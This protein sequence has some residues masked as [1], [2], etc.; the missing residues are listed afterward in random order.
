VKSFCCVLCSNKRKEERG[1]LGIQ[2]QDSNL[3]TILVLRETE[4]TSKLLESTNK[5]MAYM[6]LSCVVLMSAIPF[7]PDS[8]FSSTGFIPFIPDSSFLSLA[9]SSSWDSIAS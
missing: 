1:C 7:T 4:G 5:E 2:G 8:Y 6:E 9:M 3:K